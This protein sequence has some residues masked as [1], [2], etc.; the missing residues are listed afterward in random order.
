M[1][2]N[3]RTI[4]GKSGGAGFTKNEFQGMRVNLTKPYF[5]NRF[6][7]GGRLSK[8]DISR[9]RDVEKS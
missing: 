4:T 9:G 5:R 2:V 7:S 3:N 1:P 8:V 6:Q